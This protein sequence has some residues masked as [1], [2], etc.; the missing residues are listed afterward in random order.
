MPLLW[1]LSSEFEGGVMWN[2]MKW[3]G[4]ARSGGV[5][6]RSWRHTC[7]KASSLCPSPGT[8]R[9]PGPSNPCYRPIRA[10]PGNPCKQSLPEPLL[11]HRTAAAGH[12]FPYNPAPPFPPPP[13]PPPTTT[14]ATAPPLIFTHSPTRSLAHSLTCSPSSLFAFSRAYSFASVRVLGPS[15]GS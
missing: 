8:K 6:R 13:P 11:R 10:R 5:V 1:R 4:V 2:G 9:F 7:H 14:T 3:R 12:P 15:A